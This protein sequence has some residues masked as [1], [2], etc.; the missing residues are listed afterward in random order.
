MIV[1]YIFFSVAIPAVLWFLFGGPDLRNTAH[2]LFFVVMVL[3]LYVLIWQRKI[4][5]WLGGDYYTYGSANFAINLVSFIYTLVFSF[6]LF[7]RSTLFEFVFGTSYYKSVS[8]VPNVLIGFALA[9]LLVTVSLA[10]FTSRHL[11]PLP[12]KSDRREFETPGEGGI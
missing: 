10:V 11:E 3:H 2:V 12:K 1:F 5:K 7:H 9:G 4:F 8:Q 6:L